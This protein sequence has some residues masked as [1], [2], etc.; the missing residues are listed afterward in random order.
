MQYIQTA[1]TTGKIRSPFGREYTF[2][3]RMN[4]RGDLVWSEN[5]ITNWPNQGCGADVMAIARVALFNRI[6]RE[7][8]LNEIKFISTVHDSIVLDVPEKHVEYV[9]QQ[10]DKVFK[11]LPSLITKAYGV[12]WTLP[13]LGEVSV[14]PNMKHLTELKF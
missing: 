5:D 6:K 9:A 1:T 8:G 12:E 13:M 10:C 4:K 3:P 14:G 11:D 7:Q 2:E